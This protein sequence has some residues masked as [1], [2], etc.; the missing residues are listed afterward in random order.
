MRKKRECPYCGEHS[1]TT[2]EYDGRGRHSKRRYIKLFQCSSCQM[3]H[4][5]FTFNDI[6][7]KPERERYIDCVDWIGENYA[8]RYRGS[9]FYIEDYGF[10]S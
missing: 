5:R 3:D 4:Q 2:N 9:L 6:V 1:F 10:V 8:G 7:E